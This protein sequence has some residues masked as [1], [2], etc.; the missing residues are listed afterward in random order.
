MSYDYP[1][2]GDDIIDS[3]SILSR[4]SDLEAEDE[5]DEEDTEELRV[6]KALAEEGEGYADWPYGGTL[7][8]DSHFTEY[9]QQ[10]AEDIGAIKGDGWPNGFIDWERA[11]DALKQDYGTVDFDGVEYWIRG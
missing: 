9:A 4:I 11:A 1:D 10:L 6:L 7:I 5:L 3:R 8:R 2:N